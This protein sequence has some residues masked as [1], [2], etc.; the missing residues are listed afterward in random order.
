MFLLHHTKNNVLLFLAFVLNLIQGDDQ[1]PIMRLI[2]HHK[3][4]ASSN[5]LLSCLVHDLIQ[6]AFRS[7]I[8][9]WTGQDV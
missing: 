8:Q 2:M 7:Q 1:E 4:T 5:I 9:E 3:L 6:S